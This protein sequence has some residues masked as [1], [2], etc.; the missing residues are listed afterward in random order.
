MENGMFAA[1]YGFSHEEPPK[2]EMLNSADELRF[3]FT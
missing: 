3:G 2:A 1:K